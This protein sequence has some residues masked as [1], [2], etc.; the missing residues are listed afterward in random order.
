VLVVLA[1]VLPAIV[2][3]PAWAR[4]AEPRTVHAIGQQQGELQ[5]SDTVAQDG[6]GVSV[7]ISGA[8]V[9]AGAPG[10]AKSAGRAYVFEKSGDAW[11][12]AAEL[13]GSDTAASDYFGY[14][15]VIAGTTVVVGSP[16]YAKDAGRVYVFT[17]TGGGWQ[18]VAELK[19][20]DT[21]AGDYFGYSVAISG[22]TIG[23]GGP[24]HAKTAGRVYVFTKAGASWKQTAELKGSDT[25]A[26]DGF[27]YAVAL[28]GTT[29]AVGAPVY[30]KNAGRAYVFTDTPSGWKQAAELKGSDTV[31]E[32]GF[33]VAIAVSGATAVVGADGHA[34]GAGRAYVFT[35]SVGGWKQSAEL[36]G[37]DTVANDGFGI[38]VVL[39]GTT[40]MIGAPDHAKLA[41]RAYVFTGAAGTWKQVGELK[42]ADTVANDGFGVSVALSGTTAVV[43]APDRASDAGR[44]YVF[45]A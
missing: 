7:A 6:F 5:G 23:V 2:G 32:D 9:V 15:V 12:Q 4:G 42:G 26:D 31:G 38:S 3:G 27:G 25:A 29:A 10:Y 33:G 35:N 11:K 17:A 37:A 34:K 14:S 1:A 13:K 30:T 40:L 22:T 36:K 43:S 16:G 21:A 39:S 41:G 44:A 19:G 45:T 18:Q 24:G 8:A 28:S 20:S